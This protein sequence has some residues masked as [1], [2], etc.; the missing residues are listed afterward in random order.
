MGGINVK[1]TIVEGALK[2]IAPHHC[3][4]CG[5][6]GLILCDYCKYDI[7]RETFGGCI[8]CG[9]VEKGGIC[10]SHN[11]PIER[12]FV[13]GPREGVLE[14]VI[15]ALKF[16]RL[17]A[18]S[19]SLA[20]L[21]DDTLPL[22]PKGAV[23]V[24]IPTIRPHIRQRGYD[25]VGL[26]AS[27]LAKKR[28]LP[29]ARLLDRKTNAVQHTATSR[30]QRQAQASSAFNVRKNFDFS[31]I[32]RG[33]IILVDDITT[34]GST[35][36]AAAEKIQLAVQSQPDLASLKDVKIWGCVVAAQQSIAEKPSTTA[37]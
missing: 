26:I 14:D 33:P 27:H 36:V 12:A 37:L 31:L 25:Q 3:Y 22:L 17:K 10:K 23:L 18:A 28:G 19:A 24:P 35:L 21:F 15:D 20:E 6:V 1:N 7:T 13:V 9:E 2:I 11:S 29:V 5:K 34:T 32:G 8:L 16:G 30:S 4:S